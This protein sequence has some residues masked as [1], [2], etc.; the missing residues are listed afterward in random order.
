M[1]KLCVLAVLLLLLT[2]CGKKTK[3]ETLAD[4]CYTE[5]TQSPGVIQISVP[6]ELAAPVMQTE[7]G[8]RLYIADDYTVT[9][10]TMPGGDLSATLKNC[11]GFEWDKLTVLE[12][13]KDGMKRYDCAWTSAGEGTQS[14][15]RLMILDDAAYHYV[16]A[17]TA[18]GDET[19]DMTRVWQEL[20]DSFRISIVQ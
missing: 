10:Q 15:G 20:S 12:T 7:N 2:G 1:K 6:D 19:T 14:V 11:T 8:D 9:V 13:E 4:P 16:L 3:Y 18:A 5:Q 17:V